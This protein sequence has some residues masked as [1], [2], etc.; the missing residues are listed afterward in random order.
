MCSIVLDMSISALSKVTNTDASK[1]RIA[2]LLDET[3]FHS[4]FQHVVKGAH[5]IDQSTVA[6]ATLMY[7]LAKTYLRLGQI[8]GNASVKVGLSFSFLFTSLFL[9]IGSY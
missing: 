3:M 2:F 7:H 1:R 8:A 6:L 4:V 9:L 5:H